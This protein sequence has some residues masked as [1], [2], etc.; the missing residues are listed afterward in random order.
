TMRNT[1]M[2]SGVLLV[3]LFLAAAAN[4]VVN[5][6]EQDGWDPAE[7]QHN[8]II[9]EEIAFDNWD[10]TAEQ[11]EDN[12]NTHMKY[13]IGY[14][15]YD[16]GV[17]DDEDRD[18]KERNDDNNNE[19]YENDDEHSGDNARSSCQ[20]GKTNPRNRI[21]DGDEVSPG[22]K[23]PWVVGLQKEGHVTS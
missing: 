5:D 6:M 2:F 12:D 16:D 15:R 1:L 10:S 4:H 19:D 9:E 3:T 20:C 7:I 14:E 11:N 21:I 17:D 8:K 22:R 23:Y 13:D 18:A